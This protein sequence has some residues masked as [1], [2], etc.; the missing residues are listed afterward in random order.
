MKK[1][2]ATILIAFSLLAGTVCAMAADSAEFSFDVL[3]DELQIKIN[4]STVSSYAVNA[5]VLPRE[6][7][8]LSQSVIESKAVAVKGFTSEKKTESEIKVILKENRENGKYMI[9]VFSDGIKSMQNLVLM[10]SDSVTA[11]YNELNAGKNSGEITAFL[12]THMSDFAIEDSEDTQRIGKY[13]YSMYKAG[14]SDVQSVYRELSKIILFTDFQKNNMNFSALEKQSGIYFKNEIFQNGSLTSAQ[15]DALVVLLSNETDTD[16]DLDSIIEDRTFAAAVQTVSDSDS[17]KTLVENKFDSDERLDSYKNIKNDYKQGLIIDEIYKNKNSFKTSEEVIKKIKELSDNPKN[18]ESESTGTDKRPSAPTGGA[19]V[20]GDSGA[21][22]SSSFADIDNHWAKDVINSAKK[23]S[24]VNGDGNNNFYP[25]RNVTRAEFVKMIVSLSKWSKI[26]KK[27]RFNDVFAE[28]WY[29][30][31]IEA[32]AEKGIVGGFDGSFRPN[33]AITR[34]DA[35][36][37]L[38]RLIGENSTDAQSEEFEDIYEVS[39]YAVESIYKMT[40]MNILQGYNSLI[41]PKDNITR[42]ESVALVIRAGRRL[43]ITEGE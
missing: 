10:K 9:H 37:I 2:T 26:D 20:K 22:A 21:N 8:T 33:V 25:D 4:N 23:L 39:D 38:D 14:K 17:L 7:T 16:T 11:L 28:D 42:A 6:N 35:V 30:P 3:S 27:S 18:G 34:E 1:I 12:D 31:Y 36:V 19:T 24:V 13:I 5:I 32:A 41:R 29:A 43:G 40:R 15:K